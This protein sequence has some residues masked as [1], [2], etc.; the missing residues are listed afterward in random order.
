VHALVLADSASGV[1]RQHDFTKW[2]VIN[3]DVTVALHRDPVGE[4]IC[5][6]AQVHASPG[7]SAL[8]EATLADPSGRFGLAT[9]TLLIDERPS[10]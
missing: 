6:R 7:G 5:M 3:T 4:W 1:G 2:L 8:A 9:Q 10:A